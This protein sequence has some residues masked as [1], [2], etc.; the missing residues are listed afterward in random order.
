MP[1]AH[2]P[3]KYK[4][5]IA[6]I[7]TGLVL[8][9]SLVPMEGRIGCYSLAIGLTPDVQNFLHIPIFTV[10]TILWLRV[11]NRFSMRRGSKFIVVITATL[12]FG[13]FNELIQIVIPGRYAGIMD[14][15]LDLVGIIM[16]VLLCFHSF[17][18]E[19]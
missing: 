1:L 6:M 13:T 11:M 4:I 15:G 7:Y 17:F 12:A 9:S 3:E 19:L 18:R 8:L 16:G 2:H 10:L 14:L 5:S